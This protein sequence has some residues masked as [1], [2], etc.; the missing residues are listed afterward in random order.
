MNQSERILIT[1]RTYPT[2]ST[3]H[4][5]TVCV[6]GIAEDGTWRRLYPVPLRYLRKE[7]QFRTWDV[8]RATTRPA[9]RDRRPESRRAH[10]PTLEI[11]D[12]LTTWSSRTHWVRPTIR[13][14]LAKIVEEGLSLAPVSVTRVKEM[15]AKSTAN[16]WDGR[17]AQNLERRMLFD[18]PRPLE[19]IP[20]EFRFVWEDDDGIEH[21]S[22]AISWE[23]AQ[24]WRQYRNKYDDPIE[25]MRAKLIGDM[26]SPKN[27]V[28]FFMGNHSR[29]RKT[30]MICGWFIPPRSEV[31]CESLFD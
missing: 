11:V 26:F 13:P 25:Q 16:E 19:K 27:A 18:Q 14:S 22:L 4:Q 3:K 23:L 30:F 10:L 12:Q 28:A 29:F 17:R 7:Q 31:D 2:P 20:Y 15:T 21:D 8:I 6:G 9:K 1:V 24:A 5:E